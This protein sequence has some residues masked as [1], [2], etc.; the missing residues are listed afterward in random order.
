[1]KITI[2]GDIMC[3]PAILRGAEKEDGSYDFDVIFSKVRERLHEADYCVANFETPMA[4]KEI[5][6][7]T[8]SYY[9]FNAPDSMAK[10]MKN[11]G[12]DLVSTANNH[13]YDRGMEGAVRTLRVLD[14][15]GVAHTGSYLPGAERQGAYHFDIGDTHFAV[16]AYTYAT[17]YNENDYRS[18]LA[19]G[20]YE[21]AV[22][23]L[24]SQKAN[25]YL[26]G[27]FRGD[28]WVDKL[29]KKWIPDEEKRG[30]LKIIL[31]MEGN[32]P[33]SDDYLDE[34]MMIPYMEQLQGDIRAAKEKADVVIVYPHMG[35]QFNQKPGVFTQYVMNK[36][37]EAGAD[38][39]LAGHSHCIHKMEING[40][41]PCA[42]SL[43]NVS[44]CPYS[45]L[46]VKERLP[47]YGLAVH[48]YIEDKQIAR[49]TFSILKAV[50]K[51]GEAL[52][53]WPVDALYATLSEKQQKLLE[54]DV[55]KLHR[56]V[57]DRDLGEEW[58]LKE[59][60]LSKN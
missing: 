29:F 57:T 52:V 15:A 32:Y 18:V 28:D 22:N 16:I 48:L 5:G 59:Y 8:G 39:V 56:I 30:R 40:K 46:M 35:G 19:E 60:E 1:M 13:T 6:G 34:Q 54:K 11:A 38:A 49:T 53:S 45:S 43:G 23:L 44:M 25:T 12:I 26:P 17:N 37:L 27:V 47:E 20:E 2:L 55:R 14:E 50:Q 10:A 24:R 7:Y 31:G 51:R 33:R 41:V 58:L 4:G 42:Y 21:G 9:V 3:E 36:C